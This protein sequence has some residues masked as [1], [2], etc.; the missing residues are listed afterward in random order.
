M[1]GG[2]RTSSMWALPAAASKVSGSRAVNRCYHTMPAPCSQPEGASC[3]YELDRMRNH[4]FQS[5][6]HGNHRRGIM[7]SRQGTLEL[8]Q[9]FIMIT[10]ACLAAASKAGWKDNA[11]E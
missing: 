5:N 7:H 8:A 10:H 9:P 4:I 2:R 3:S 6:L 1:S 11:G